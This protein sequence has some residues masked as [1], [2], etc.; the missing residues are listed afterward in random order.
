MGGSFY[1]IGSGLARI[2]K[3]PDTRVDS[4]ITNGSADN[5]NL[6]RTGIIDIA[7]SSADLAYE[8]SQGKNKD[9]EKV[10]ACNIATLYSSFVYIIAL[11]GSGINKVEDMKN[12]RVSVGEVGSST[13]I[14]ADRIL[15]AAG[16]DAKKDIKRLNLQTFSN[17]NAM[18]DKNIDAFFSW[19]SFSSNLIIELINY[20]SIKF[21]FI[22]GSQYV[23][24]IVAIHGPIYSKVTLPKDAY[25]GLN[26]DVLGIGGSN[27]LLVSEDMNEQIAYNI[28]KSIFDNLPEI[29]K[30]HIE[31]KRF[32]LQSAVADSPLPYHPGA[33]KFY[34][35]K[36]LM[37]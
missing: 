31:T 3:L 21:K 32:N 18:S 6:L 36:G 16:L 30:M 35:E 14:I 12:K 11:E 22:D 20:Q 13:E 15:E 25:K 37:K 7:I 19:G 33:I 2:L 24:K 8:I 34:K 10:P 23:D 1:P 26:Q 29:Q 9:I 4:K 5:M 28:T 17:I 27:V